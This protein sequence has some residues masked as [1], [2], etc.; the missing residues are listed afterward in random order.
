MSRTYTIELKRTGSVRVRHK[1]LSRS[2]AAALIARAA[3]RQDHVAIIKNAEGLCIGC[4]ST[5]RVP[6]NAFYS[7][8]GWLNKTV[9]NKIAVQ[10][11]RKNRGE[12]Y[13]SRLPEV[14]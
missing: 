2:T 4:T 10:L 11:D 3:I 13:W 14:V 7:T 9:N 6:S 8:D 12:L 5:A 1:G